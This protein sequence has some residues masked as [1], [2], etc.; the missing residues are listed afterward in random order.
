MKYF[1]CAFLFKQFMLP[2]TAYLNLDAQKNSARFLSEAVL[3]FFF[4]VCLLILQE[5]LITQSVF[6]SELIIL[7]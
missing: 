4:K 3:F 1:T 2:K 6:H 7:N 5:I